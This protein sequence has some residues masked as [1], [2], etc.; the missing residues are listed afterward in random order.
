MASIPSSYVRTVPIAALLAFASAVWIVASF[1]DT[2]VSLAR[3]WTSSESFAHGPL[4]P[5][6]SAWLVWR[7]RAELRPLNPRPWWPAVILLALSGLAW[8]VAHLAG[9]NAAEQFALVGFIVSAVVL[10]CGRQVAGAIS[11]PLGFLFFAVPFGTFLLPIMMNWTADF[12]VLAIRAVGVPVFR[13]GML[14]ELPTGRWSVVESCSGVRYLLAAVPLACVYAYLTFDSILSRILFIALATF[15]ALVGNWLRAFM[16]VMLG[17]F[18]NMRIAVGVD[19]I[20]Y[21]WLFF[22]V[23]CCLAAWLGHFIPEL[24]GRKGTPAWP[25]V[26]GGPQRFGASD[27]NV[28]HAFIAFLATVVMAFAVPHLASALV[29]DA[30]PT[31]VLSAKALRLV[32]EPPISTSSMDYVPEFHRAYEQVLGH[33]EIDARVKVMILRYVNQHRGGEMINDEN[34]IL[35]GEA[36]TSTWQI[37]AQKDVSVRPSGGITTTDRASEYIIAGPSG[38]YLVWSWYVVDGAIVTRPSSVKLRM[39]RS[40][41]AGHGDDSTAWFVWS[42]VDEGVEQARSRVQVEAGRLLAAAG[43]VLR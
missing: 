26:A 14:F 30:E 17:H 18:S 38:R 43:S 13:E 16:I 35:P 27:Q 15:S 23:I 28:F 29:S 34:R 37:L 22:G 4:V 39:V 19:H 24:S 25:T 3:V 9:V 40:I 32:E 33:S 7:M 41:L 6:V 42:K 5:L 11:F 36:D 12:T 2:T 10:I 1:S 20:I 8:T 31:G 21:G